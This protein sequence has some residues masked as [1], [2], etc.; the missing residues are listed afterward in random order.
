M[1]RWVCDL[2]P[3]F[4]GMAGMSP[5]AG[6]VLD[7]RDITE[8]LTRGAASPHEELVLFANEIPVGI[9]TQDWKYYRDLMLPVGAFGYQEL[10]DERGSH[11]ENYSVADN[12]P[13]VAKAMKARLAAAKTTLA[14]FKHGDIPEV[15]K[16]LCAQMAHIQD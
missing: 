11:A 2:L 5:L 7:G 4:R 13:E 8:R 1:P 9:G 6:V 16:K 15:Y 14:P 3:I 10:Y 12:H